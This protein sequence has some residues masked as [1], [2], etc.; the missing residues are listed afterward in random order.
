[1]EVD[2]ER[3]VAAAKN[4]AE[5]RESRKRNETPQGAWPVEV[6]QVTSGS[7]TQ[8]VELG[9][10]KVRSSMVSVNRGRLPRKRT[11]RKVRRQ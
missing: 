6:G 11:A 10:R 4:L 8:G 3:S 5:R 9:K 1:M 2:E 7:A